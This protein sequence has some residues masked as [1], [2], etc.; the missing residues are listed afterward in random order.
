MRISEN[1]WKNIDFRKRKYRQLRM[2]LDK[3]VT[4]RDNKVSAFLTCDDGRYSTE[5]IDRL[6]SDLVKTMDDYGRRH[7]M[8]LKETDTDN[9]DE[10]CMPEKFREFVQDY[11]YCII[12]L[13]TCDM[14]WVDKVFA[15]PF[16]DSFQQILIHSMEV[17]RLAIKSDRAKF[18]ELWSESYYGARGDGGL[19][20]I[21]TLAYESLKNTDI[22]TT[23]T[24]EMRAM[25]ESLCGKQ[26][27]EYEEYLEE[28][29]ENVMSDEE[30]E[31]A[32]REL[33]EDGTEYS[34]GEEE[35]NRYMDEMLER[36]VKSENEFK[37]SFVDEEV[38]SQR[39][40]RLREIFYMEMDSDEM[41]FAM[42]EFDDLV[43]GTLDVFLCRH[44]MSLYADVEKF[45]RSYIYIKKQ[46]DMVKE[47]HEEV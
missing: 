41:K 28:A 27:A 44:G 24:P 2:E 15:W 31:A 22:S 35:Y 25:V 23:L 1:E 12:R 38:Y 45:V 34:E 18:C 46:I 26:N 14:E 47:L 9:M 10:A 5:S 40:I 11:L 7:R 33:A 30:I 29:E 19:F 6:V 37:L 20:D 21:F 36:S 3:V 42:S 13:M 39:Y 32:L 4:G 16:E 8:W 17:K 43:E